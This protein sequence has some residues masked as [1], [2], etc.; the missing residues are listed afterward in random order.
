MWRDIIFLDARSRMSF[1]SLKY[2]FMRTIFPKYTMTLF[3]HQA[4]SAV[5]PDVS[6]DQMYIK[7]IF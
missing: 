3:I 6:Y 2:W 7:Y 1:V 4:M 5:S